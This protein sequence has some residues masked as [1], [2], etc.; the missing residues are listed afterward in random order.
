MRRRR[1]GRVQ[2]R[3][4]CRH[5]IRL[6]GNMMDC[7]ETVRRGVRWVRLGWD[8]RNWRRCGETVQRSS[9]RRLNLEVCLVLADSTALHHCR[10]VQ[11]LWELSKL[12][13]SAFLH[14]R[15]TRLDMIQAHNLAHRGSNHS[16]KQARC[17]TIPDP[18]HQHQSFSHNN[19]NLSTSHNKCNNSSPAH[20][21]ATS[22][23]PPTVA[24]SCTRDQVT[25]PSLVMAHHILKARRIE[26]KLRR[27]WRKRMRSSR[28]HRDL[29][30]RGRRRG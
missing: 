29:L 16:H 1:R 30:R 19:H 14:T 23:S 24:Q 10:V 8:R 20:N 28:G 26:V 17:Q 18:H 15:S 7:L 12:T 6:R 3:P 2:D 25:T 5:I 21:A 22:T 11:G 27:P 4:Q 9:S 13:P